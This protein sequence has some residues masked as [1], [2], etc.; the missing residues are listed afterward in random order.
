MTTTLEAVNPF[1]PI[2]RH[3]HEQMAALGA[4]RA[5]LTAD[6]RL[7]MEPRA[8]RRREN[9]PTASEVAA[10][11]SD[12]GPSQSTRST[13]DL[14]LSLRASLDGLLERVSLCNP[15]YLPLQYVLMYPYGECGMVPQPHAGDH[16]PGA[17][18]RAP[19]LA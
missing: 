9:M 4:D 2:Y 11:V 3:A 13:Q 15:H 7:V 14:H 18:P 16:Q 8:D 19:L 6:L 10:I 5:S 1:I 17:H 12:T